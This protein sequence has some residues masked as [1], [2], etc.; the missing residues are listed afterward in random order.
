V[1]LL[2]TVKLVLGATTEEPMQ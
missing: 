1:T 2:K